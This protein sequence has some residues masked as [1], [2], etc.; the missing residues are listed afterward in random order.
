MYFRRYLSTLQTVFEIFLLK[1]WLY[2]S[3]ETNLE[4]DHNEFTMEDSRAPDSPRVG[5]T[6]PHER[7][8]WQNPDENASQAPGCGEKK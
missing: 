3:E 5:G 2:F 6:I 8:Q 4:Q 7:C 1:L